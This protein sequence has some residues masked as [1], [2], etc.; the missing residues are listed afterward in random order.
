MDRDAKTLPPADLAIYIATKG[1][2]KKRQKLRHMFLSQGRDL[3]VA[4]TLF[5][6]DERVQSHAKD[7]ISGSS[8]YANRERDGMCQL[9]P[10][11]FVQHGH[12]A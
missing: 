3:G 12:R 5:Q 9:K 1:S 7:S 6:T 4:M 8:M 10:D 11:L 2:H